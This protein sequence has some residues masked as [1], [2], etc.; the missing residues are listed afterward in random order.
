MQTEAFYLSQI[1]QAKTPDGAWNGIVELAR[2]TGIAAVVKTRYRNAGRQNGE[3]SVKLE[4][5]R[6]Y[7]DP[8]L[9]A[10]H[11]ARR[12]A[13]VSSA[14]PAVLWSIAPTDQDAICPRFDEAGL[15]VAMAGSRKTAD[16][17]VDR[18]IGTLAMRHGIRLHAVLT[19]PGMPAA[20]D[21]AAEFLSFFAEKM[22]APDAISVLT[23]VAGAY[24]GKSAVLA[25]RDGDGG[26]IL[27]PMEIECIRWAVAGKSLQDIADILGVSYRSVRYQIDQARER[28]GY[29]TNLQTYVRAAVDYGL[30][31]ILPPELEGKGNR[32]VS[33]GVQS[34]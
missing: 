34:P 31:P 21:V 26:V 3:D 12:T 16:P 19:V 27:K 23:S 17:F 33:G 13:T 18:F 14:P 6:L 24:A 8:D 1:I 9:A 5:P 20:D 11:P 10:Q 7:L 15:P 32:M 22:P 28:Y 29:A 4:L 30:D 2:D 25:S